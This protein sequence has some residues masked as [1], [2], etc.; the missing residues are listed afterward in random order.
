MISRY[1]R[2]YGSVGQWE[3]VCARAARRTALALVPETLALRLMQVFFD[4]DATL[5]HVI[6]ARKG[7]HGGPPL[8]SSK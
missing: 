6:K 3:N 2:Y 4:Y 1:S 5:A 7:G 8:Q